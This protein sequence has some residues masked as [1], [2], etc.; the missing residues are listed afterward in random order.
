MSVQ[1]RKHVPSIKKN[2]VFYAD[3]LRPN[4]WKMSNLYSKDCGNYM[5]NNTA[6]P[7]RIGLSAVFHHILSIT[8]LQDIIRNALENLGENGNM[9]GSYTQKHEC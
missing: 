8:V 1:T 6:H 5:Y 2:L 3:S 4:T 9:L 7:I